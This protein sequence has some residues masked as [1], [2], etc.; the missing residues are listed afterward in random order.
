[1]KAIVFTAAALLALPSMASAQEVPSIQV[2]TADLNLLVSGNREK[3]ERR[4]ERA[5]WNECRSEARG[6]QKML[7]EHECRSDL[8]KAAD[9][10]V[11]LAVAD[12]R[13]R[14]LAAI[15]TRTEG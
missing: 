10:Q 1:M 12:A 8:L 4:I 13:A 11:A 2:G 3:L 6:V 14:R 7:A 5:I 15:D 9:K